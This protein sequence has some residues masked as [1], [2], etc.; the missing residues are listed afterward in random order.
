MSAVTLAL[1]S[2]ET[3]ADHIGFDDSP[4]QSGPK[5]SYDQDEDVCIDGLEV[6][7]CIYCTGPETD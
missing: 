5:V 4:E 7:G 2:L 3:R 6:D 1:R